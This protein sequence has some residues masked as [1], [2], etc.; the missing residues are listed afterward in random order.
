[1]GL[2]LYWKWDETKTKRQIAHMETYNIGWEVGIEE[3][4]REHGYDGY[5]FTSLHG[6][7]VF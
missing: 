2:I 4:A 5:Y 3:Y 6:L 7:K 1:M